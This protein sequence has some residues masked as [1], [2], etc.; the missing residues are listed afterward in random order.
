M[1]KKRFVTRESDNIRIEV[2]EGIDIAPHKGMQEA[3]LLSNTDITVCGGNRGGGKS[4]AII[5]D[6]C[7][8][9]DKPAFRPMFFR[10]T[11]EDYKKGGSVWDTAKSVYKILGGVSTDSNYT[12]KFPSGARVV[13]GQ[14]D[15][16][17][18]TALERQFQGMEIPAIYLDEANQYQF[19]TI[20]KLMQCNRNS[21]GIR[22][23]IIMTCN[24][25]PDSWL[26][27]FIDWYIGE[28]GFIIK[29]RDR[30][31]RYFYVNGESV[32]DV[33]W[34]NTRK[35]VY[36][37][38]KAKIDRLI[39]PDMA[40]QGYTYDNYIKSF[41]FIQGNLSENK[42]LLAN[43]K[44]Y[45]AN[46]SGGSDEE[47]ARNIMGNWKVKLDGEEMVKRSDIIKLP[48]IVSKT[49]GRRRLSI[50]VALG[51]K[52]NCIM[53]IWDGLHIM[54]IKAYGFLTPQGLKSKVENLMDRY[55]IKERDISY[56]AVG[57][58]Q[59]LKDFKRAYAVE[60]NAQP[61]DDTGFDK[62]K[63]QIIYQ[64][65]RL[66]QDGEISID[67]E[68]FESKFEIGTASNKIK[69]SLRD[70]LLQERK[71]MQIADDETKIK[72]MSKKQFKKDIGRSPDFI[73]A[74]AYG[75]VHTLYK[76]KKRRGIRGLGNL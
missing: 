34:G 33:V 39:T 46:V 30:A 3:V 62:L 29:E 47:V 21:K 38:V 55:N 72:M 43:D 5:M 35:E 48:D 11:L 15:N 49:D 69:M 24:P 20:T 65:G 28:D 19:K 42:T 57:S 63:S 54:D 56:D 32:D 73:E 61:I 44:N 14:I 66:L 59:V 58:G 40:E 70:I 12:T 53:V 2:R 41:T 7:Y 1:K 16:E 23:R 4:A 67:E 26:A 8:D 22:N 13:F 31:V 68:L 37:Q 17:S 10:K 52:D 76:K 75:I 64:L 45:V 18:R 74:I 27:R 50:D 60:A 36:L 6:S 71:L 25:D 51:G 9:V